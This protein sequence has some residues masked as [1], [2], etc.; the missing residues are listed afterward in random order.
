MR[1]L[2]LLF[3]GFHVEGGLGTAA[4]Y[5]VFGFVFVFLGI[6]LLIGFFM[7]LG[8]I[9]KKV[10]AKKKASK[11]EEKLAPAPVPEAEDGITPEIVAAITAA[12]MAYYEQENV[13]CDFVVRRIKKL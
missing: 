1:G 5:T 6:T 2:L 11:K 10:N 4:F 13:P 3:D 7:A 8:A 9:M 12:L